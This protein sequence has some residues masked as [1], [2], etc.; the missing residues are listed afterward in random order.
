M[1]LRAGS[2]GLARWMPQRT[3]TFE[4]LAKATQV[5]F[6]AIGRGTNRLQRAQ[7]LV[8]P[9]RERPA[10]PN[11]RLGHV[12]TPTSQDFSA[13][14][15]IAE[16]TRGPLF[17]GRLDGLPVAVKYLSNPRSSSSGG[18][19]ADGSGSAGGSGSSSS[20]S[21][22]LL[23]RLG[24]PRRFKRTVQALG[25]AH[26]PHVVTLLGSCPEHAMLV[27]EFMEGGSLEGRLFSSSPRPPLTWQVR[28]VGCTRAALL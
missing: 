16:G 1:L 22:G 28:V 20:G 14:N 2:C 12:A 24:G 18:S 15:K 13:A 6:K 8:L 7:V 26:H 10:D 19:T 3:Y 5:F 11:V 17:K 27:W 9:C 21:T 4:Q 25:A 23:S